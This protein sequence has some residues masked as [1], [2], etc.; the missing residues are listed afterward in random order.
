[1]A[2]GADSLH[3]ST[4][5]SDN[6]EL[7]RLL[8]DVDPA[9]VFVKNRQ[10]HF[11]FANKALA[12]IY[13][14]TVE[15]IQGKTDADFNPD[16]GE[17]EHFLANDLHVMD[18]REELFIAEEHVTDAAGNGVWLQTTK[19]PV[20][21]ADDRCDYVLGVSFDITA[22]K[23]AEF[24][25]RELQSRL[26]QAQRM[27]SLGVMAGGIAHDLN[28]IL[29][30]LVA[31][32]ELIQRRIGDDPTTRQLLT[33]M[34]QATSR[35]AA[36]IQDLLTLARRGIHD[37]KPIN[38]NDVLSEYLRSPGLR[39]LQS[40]QP[41]VHIQTDLAP[42]LPAALGSSPHFYQVIMNLVTNAFEAMVNGGQLTIATRCEKLEQSFTA[43]CEIAKGDYVLLEVT[44]TGEGIPA[45]QLGS[46]F[47]PFVSSKVLGRSGSGLGLSV[48]YGV[49]QDMNGHI[50][51]H[52]KP[53]EGA[54]F[55]VGLPSLAH[56]TTAQEAVDVMA[57]RGTGTVLIIDDLASQRNLGSRVLEALGYK[58]LVAA[59]CADAL[60]TL[61][62][63]PAIE[64]IMIDMLMPENP[65]GLDTFRAI[66]EIRPGLP[67]L[68][69]SGYADNGRIRTACA[70]GV[71][72]VVTKPYTQQVLG[73]AIRMALGSESD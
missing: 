36:V 3:Q 31:Y 30:P 5:F 32:P 41:D 33:D 9:L 58:V 26:A 53:G 38:L 24:R 1:M 66:Q 60:K 72:G 18:S 70:E 14:T 4:N 20:I 71:L 50:D 37:L 64:L 46:I 11:V 56:G 51:V 21:D 6:P 16:R 49:I 23:Q 42:E 54:R 52:S 29:G 7:L 22:R 13:G 10:G 68:I 62:E 28:N 63:L 39:S 34:A 69:V 47:E 15:N 17:I 43:H 59:N 67:C 65:D 57:P 48:V 25:E 2:D 40:R 35:A 8:Y 45:D 61:R 55:L 19:R 73:R 27:E 12:N 44:D